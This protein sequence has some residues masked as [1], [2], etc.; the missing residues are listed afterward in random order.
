MKPF[1]AI[2]SYLRA[3]SVRGTYLIAI[4]LIP[5]LFSLIFILYAHTAPEGAAYGP[6]WLA[7]AYAFW[8]DSIGLS[9]LL[10][11]GGAIVLDCAEKEGTPR[12]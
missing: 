5:I 3:F 2:K 1:T 11:I 6:L 8:V 7:R 10:L 4:G 9:I 12:E